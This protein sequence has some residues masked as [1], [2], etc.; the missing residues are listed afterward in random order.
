MPLGLINPSNPVNWHSPLN[1]GL[2]AWWTPINRFSGNVFPDAI[3]RNHGGLIANPTW[4]IGQHGP[5]VT[6][7]GTSQYI[8]VNDSELMRPAQLTFSAWVKIDNLS[9]IKSTIVTKNVNSAW[10][11]PYTSFQMYLRGASSQATMAVAIGS[12]YYPVTVSATL[13]ADYELWTLTV[14][15]S[16]YRLYRNRTKIAEAGMGGPINYGAYP[17]LIGAYKNGGTP[18]EIFDGKIREVRFYN[19]SLDPGDV[20][21]L[22]D[23]I[24]CGNPTVFN[25]I[26]GRLPRLAASTGGPFPWYLDQSAMSG[27]LQTMG[28]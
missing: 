10:S 16:L 8:S 21:K 3:A 27:G 9:T 25:R 22:Y 17:I 12:S 13:T 14:S 26:Q 1:R 15:G 28:L 23:E 24:S 18:G 11:P 2:I 7:N 5:A 20:A 19:R 6:L 4:A